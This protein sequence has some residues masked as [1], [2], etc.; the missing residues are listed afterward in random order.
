MP[1]SLSERVSDQR[2]YG[3]LAG[4]C[5]DRSVKKFPPQTISYHSHEESLARRLSTV[6]NASRDREPK[7]LLLVETREGSAPILLLNTRGM[8]KKSLHQVGSFKT[9]QLALSSRTAASVCR[10]WRPS[11][12]VKAMRCVL[13]SVLRLFTQTIIG[14]FAQKAYATVATSSEFCA[15]CFG[16]RSTSV[17]KNARITRDN[18]WNINKP[19]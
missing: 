15:C 6:P 11:G 4:R 17:S 14:Q 13:T 16:F 8:P 12:T 9:G 19:V 18:T 7:E 5:L 10:C 1:E 3:K 2:L